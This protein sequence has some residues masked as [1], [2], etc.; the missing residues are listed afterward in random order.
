MG[1]RLILGLVAMVAVIAIGGIGFAAWTSTISAQ[2][3]AYAGSLGVLSWVGT[4][5]NSPGVSDASVCNAGS[6]TGST[7]D[8]SLNGQYFA[9]GDICYFSDTYQL[10]GGSV[11]AQVTELATFSDNYAACGL[12]YWT[13]GDN[14]IGGQTFTAMQLT[15]PVSATGTG[16]TIT[17]GG[18]PTAFNGYFELSPSA[19]LACEGDTFSFSVTLT[20]TAV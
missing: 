14:I 16:P 11:D 2:G 3:N 4:P 19:P 7:W 5:S 1:Q 15:G 10:V 12:Q 9:P 17:P 13:Y 8:N 18:T 6:V 20:A